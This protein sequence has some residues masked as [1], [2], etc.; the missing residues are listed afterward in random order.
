[1]TCHRLQNTSM[2]ATRL[3]VLLAFVATAA[4]LPSACVALTGWKSF[5]KNDVIMQIRAPLDALF[6]EQVGPAPGAIP[7]QSVP[8]YKVVMR[9]VLFVQNATTGKVT[10]AVSLDGNA[11]GT[12]TRPPTVVFLSTPDYTGKSATTTLTAKARGMPAEGC[13]TDIAEDGSS[14]PRECMPVL[15]DFLWQARG[16]RARD[17]DSQ[18]RQVINDYGT[19]PPSRTGKIT[20]VVG[21][22]YNATNTFNAKVVKA[23]T[24]EVCEGVW[25]GHGRVKPED[26]SCLKQPKQCSG[27]R[28]RTQFVHVCLLM[29]DAEPA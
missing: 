18:D 9:G 20:G 17:F 19:K 26:A 23:D 22:R 8:V 12:A 3:A 25:A 24:K 10:R 2:A 13:V 28:M 1:M 7:T 5:T 16:V 6:L 29:A 27:A 4:L 15:V 14:G 11:T 21:A